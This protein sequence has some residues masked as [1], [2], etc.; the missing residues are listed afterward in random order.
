[1]LSVVKRWMSGDHAFYMTPDDEEL[2][3][4]VVDGFCADGTAI[5]HTLKG[6]F[7]YKVHKDELQE[8]E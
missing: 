4:V 5:V 3:E 1:M 7:I 2:H 8:G 6:G